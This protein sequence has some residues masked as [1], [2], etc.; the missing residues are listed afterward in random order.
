MGDFTPM[1][2]TDKKLIG[3]MENK[4]IR[5]KSGAFADILWNDED[6]LMDF[7]GDKVYEIDSNDGRRKLLETLSKVSSP[8]HDSWH[9]VLAKLKKELISA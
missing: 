5:D 1:N 9:K 8:S 7:L 4:S 6:F 3:I 2:D